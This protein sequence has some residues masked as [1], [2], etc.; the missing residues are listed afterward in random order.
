M[1]LRDPWLP[2]LGQVPRQPVRPRRHLNRRAA[3]SRSTARSTSVASRA[4]TTSSKL[5]RSSA[6]SQ[7]RSRAASSAIPAHVVTPV[8]TQW[9]SPGGGRLSSSAD[10]RLRHVVDVAWSDRA[11]GKDA[12]RLAAPD[13]HRE[14]DRRCSSP[15]PRRTGSRP[16]G[17]NG[18]APPPRTTRPVTSTGRSCSTAPACPTLY[19]VGRARPS[20]T[21]SVP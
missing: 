14:F 15:A 2:E 3:A 12:Y 17:R 9:Y 21:K 11:V 6:A 7:P 20:N 5:T 13:A 4:S 10:R 18:P 8:L 16:A 19:R 1:R